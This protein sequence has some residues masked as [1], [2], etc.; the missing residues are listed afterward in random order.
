LPAQ[1]DSR[2]RE[3]EDALERRG[4]QELSRAVHL[5]ITSTSCG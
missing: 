2:Q 3:R 4:P 5:S 1:N